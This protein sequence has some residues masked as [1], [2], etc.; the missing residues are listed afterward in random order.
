LD[1]DGAGVIDTPTMRQLDT[2]SLVTLKQRI[3]REL[4]RRGDVE[5]TEWT[6]GGE[7]LAVDSDTGELAATPIPLAQ[8]QLLREPDDNC[9]KCAGNGIYDGTNWDDPRIQLCPCLWGGE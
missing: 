2:G 6:D 5:Q 7:L 4:M 8:R 1:L 9:P 3:E